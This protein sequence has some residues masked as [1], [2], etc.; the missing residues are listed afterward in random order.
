MSFQEVT[1]QVMYVAITVI[2]PIVSAYVISLI[3]SKIREVSMMEEV[4][5]NEV[6]SNLINEASDNVLDAV[7][8]VNQVYTDSLKASGNFNSQSQKKAFNMA[9]EEAKKIIADD[10]KGIIESV[11]GSFDEWLKIKIE[12]FVGSLKQ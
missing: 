6:I 11:Y 3:R 8:Y 7:M 1:Q 9:M 12:A 10:S 5:R 2:L 4:K